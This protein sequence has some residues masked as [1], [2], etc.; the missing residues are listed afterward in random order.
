MRARAGSWWGS[1]ARRRPTAGAGL[2]V[3]L[4]LRLLDARGEPLPDGGAALSNLDHVEVG[5]LDPRLAETEIVIASDVTN[6]L[7]GPAGAAATFA[8]QKGANAATV[9]E[10]DAALVRWG[11]EIR[12]ATGRDVTDV[13]GAG[14]AGGTTAG[15]L[16]FTSAVVLPGVEEVAELVGLAAAL[17]DADLVL[18]GEGRADEQ[19]LAG[20]AALG[21]ARLRARHPGGPPVRRPRPRRRDPGGIRCLRRRP[22]DHRSPDRPG[23]R[24][25]R[26]R[27]PPGER[28]SH[29]WPAPSE[30]AGASAPVAEGGHQG[31]GKAT[32][33]AAKAA[34]AAAKRR[35]LTA[36][37]RVRRERIGPILDRL[38]ERYGWPTWSGPRLDPVAELVLTI[39]AQNTADT[40]SHRAF[41]A[42]Q[43]AYPGW[44]AVLAAPT[45]ELE[46]VIRPGGLAPTK[47]RRI[48]QVLAEVSDATNG[49]W[50]LGFLAEWPLDQA[51]DWLVALPGIG[52]KTASI[53]L[54]FAFG[55]PA[56][57]VDTHV[58]RVAERLGLIPKRTDLTRAHDLLEEV[59]PPESMYAGHVLLIRHGREVCRAPRPI[60]GLCPLTDLCPYFALVQRGRARMAPIP[61]TPGSRTAVPR[62]AAP[63]LGRAHGLSQIGRSNTTRSS[64][65]PS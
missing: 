48:Q 40:N 56:L 3:E 41:V 38:A 11:A 4:G 63:R 52:R 34:K 45:D 12:R 49:T 21:V 62:R 60:C 31:L 13:P 25:G 54:L 22:A 53:V 64:P 44:D 36:Q 43:A 20:K 6:P 16:G 59:V 51:R 65:G 8:T 47:S 15:L 55:R 33:K 29:G 7:T 1:A 61:K 27:A 32:T 28:R 23:L 57:P 10:L 5:D 50:D 37:R 17:Q 58:Y 30:S 35:R 2:L 39:L 24:H 46:D 19:T 26:H 14:A 9:A 42:L 18:T